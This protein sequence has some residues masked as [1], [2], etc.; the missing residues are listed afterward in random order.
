[1]KSELTALTRPRMSSGVKSCTSEDRT[2]TLTVSAAPRIISIST[3]S[4]TSVEKAKTIV[5][6]PKMATAQSILMP[7]P[8]CRGK[9]ARNSDIETAPIAGAMRSRPRAQGPAKRMSRA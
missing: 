6:R 3:D 4:T 2:T 8:R 9:R 7:T 5:A 1:M